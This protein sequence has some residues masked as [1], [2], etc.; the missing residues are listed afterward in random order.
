MLSRRGEIIPKTLP[1]FV[2]RREEGLSLVLLLGLG[3]FCRRIIANILHF[4]ISACMRSKVD[5]VPYPHI[6]DYYKSGGLT[7]SKLST[8]INDKICFATKR[9][10]L[11]KNRGGTWKRYFVERKGGVIDQDIRRLEPYREIEYPGTIRR[12][13]EGGSE[14]TIGNSSSNRKERSVRVLRLPGDIVVYTAVVESTSTFV[15]EVSTVREE[16]DLGSDRKFRRAFV[17]RSY[18]IYS[19]RLKDDEVKHFIEKKNERKKKG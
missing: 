16:E 4:I 5:V 6:D 1:L 13:G 9:A 19:G 15:V 11:N 10:V 7:S 18:D 17:R 12:S 3:C 2:L 8:M 14:V